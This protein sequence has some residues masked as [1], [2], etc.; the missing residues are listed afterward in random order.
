L[1]VAL[2]GCLVA[3]LRRRPWVF[4]IRDLWPASIQAV[5]AV[6][7]RIL[8]LFEWLELFLY[9]RADRIICLTASFQQDLAARGIPPG[10]CDVV[11]NGVDAELFNP[12]NVKFNARERLGIAADDFLAGY[13]G[14]VG[15]AHGLETLLD[16]AELCR[17]H[18]RMKFLVMGEGAERERL[19]ASARKRGL[20]QV[21]FRDFVPHE[22]IPSYLAGLDASIIHLKPDPLFRTVIPS[23]IFES[24]AAAVP[25]VYAVEG[26]GARIVA[27]SGAGICVPP[28]N[29]RAMA[30]ALLELERDPAG[31][32]RMG[33]LGQRAA[34][35]HYS[36]EAKARA[37]IDSLDCVLGIPPANVVAFPEPSMTY[38]TRTR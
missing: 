23:K 27:D 37:V 15:M 3:K 7:G 8:R 34:R 24:M 5:G 9:R 19:E 6:N 1:F 35:E 2:A 20:R 25:M 29:P 38:S 17:E 11:T 36:R 18:P 13:V 14:T 10:K 26:E 32:R 12:A 4:E 28:G 16:A 30:D 22:E 33:A 31:G 21:L